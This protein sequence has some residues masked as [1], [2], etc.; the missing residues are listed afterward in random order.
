[1]SFAF[2]PEEQSRV[3]VA[4]FLGIKLDPIGYVDLSTI[5]VLSVMY[6]VEFIALCYQ[7]YN[8]DYLPLKA[9][10]VPIMFSLYFGAISWLMG[11]IFTGGLVH[12]GQSPILRNCKFTI[13]WLR[14]CIGAYYVTSIFALRCYSLYIVFY[15]GKAFKGK[16]AITSLG[17]AIVSIALFGIISML[18]PTRMV[19]HYEEI[20]DMC[21]IDR[22]Y[23]VAVLLVIWSIW[24]YTAIMNW[25]MRKIPFCFNER[26]EMFTSFIILLV[27]SL[28]NSIA[29]LV[30]NVYPAS[31]G[32]RNA[33]LY[34]N[35]VGAS[36]GY[37]VVMWEPTYGC[38]FHR[39]EYLQYWIN[40][41]K[42]DQMER[43]YDYSTNINNET[44]LNLVDYPDIPK[45]ESLCASTQNSRFETHAMGDSFRSH[46]TTV[47]M[48]T[49]SIHSKPLN[50]NK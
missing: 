6:G 47:Y 50:L 14:V 10:N 12:L 38:L 2:T 4:A 17:I 9:K 18:M 44:T 11:D 42:E 16:V 23:I 40:I 3:E 7:L 15:K 26:V 46:Q 36:I 30:I 48:G 33:L 20:L 49:E 43:E 32:W 21:Y 45:A 1:M 31:R 29:L 41:L 19:T 25:R 8:R 35:H 22:Y 13:I 39:E 24:I 28:M 37:W 27:V 5:V 34:T